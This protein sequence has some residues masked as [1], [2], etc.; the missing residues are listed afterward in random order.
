MWV[1]SCG[2]YVLGSEWLVV[3]AEAGGGGERVQVV[4][5]QAGIPEALAKRQG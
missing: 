3:M 4:G 2:K 5:R 1:A